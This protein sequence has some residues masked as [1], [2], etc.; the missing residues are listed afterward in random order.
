MNETISIPSYYKDKKGREEVTARLETLIDKIID[1]TLSGDSS[2]LN[3]NARELF[4]LKFD[5]KFLDDT[6]FVVVSR[7]HVAITAMEIWSRKY[8]SNLDGPIFLLDTL[9]KVSSFIKETYLPYCRDIQKSI[10]HKHSNH[11]ALG[12][13]GETIALKYMSAN[14]P[15]HRAFASQGL[16]SCQKKLTKRIE[17][18]IIK[19][20]CWL[21]KENEIWV[22]NLRNKKG[23]YYTYLHLAALIRTSV[24]LNNAG[25][26]IDNRFSRNRLYT[27]FLLYSKYYYGKE[28]PYM[29][30]TKIPIL[31]Q[32][33]GLIFPADKFIAPR[34]EGKEGAFMDV[35][36]N[37]V[38]FDAVPSFET[39]K[40][41]RELGPFP[42]HSYIMNTAHNLW[43]IL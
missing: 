8:Q 6:K 12:L 43:A 23:L 37:K 4:S 40:R 26:P 32:L 25:Y 11:G 31:R 10:L 22:E 19:K 15:A 17:K 20:D 7:Y 1:G 36:S 9:S 18:S 35:V 5:P 33:Q 24:T 39:S 16:V 2:E 3:N 13:M 34:P 21:G 29:D 38:F 30:R 27:A 41:F 28:W 14:M 42:Y